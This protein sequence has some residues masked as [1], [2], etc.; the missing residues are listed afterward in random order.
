MAEDAGI[1]VGHVEPAV[2]RDRAREQR[3]DLRLVANIARHAEH[4]VAGLAQPLDRLVQRR[5]VDVAPARAKAAAVARPMPE[6]AP[7]T[8]A[9]SPLKS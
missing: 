8:S 3:F 9:T 1:I 4:L 5:R 2:G 7:V 6:A